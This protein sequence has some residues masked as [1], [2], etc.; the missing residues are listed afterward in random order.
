MTLGIGTLFVYDD[1]FVWN[2][3]QDKAFPLETGDKP[4]LTDTNLTHSL[5]GFPPHETFWNIFF[6]RVSSLFICFQ[7]ISVTNL[8]H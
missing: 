5:K 2:R 8:A 4:N 1:V 6:A 3:I 7:S